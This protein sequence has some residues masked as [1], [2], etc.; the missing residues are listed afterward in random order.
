MKILM[1]A[2]Y[3]ATVY[4][5]PAQVIQQLAQGLGQ[6]G[7]AIDIITTP[8]N[9]QQTLDV[10]LNTWLPA[11]YPAKH[12]AEHPGQHPPQS[13][14]RVQYF[15]C[16]HQNDFILSPALWYWL[17]H[18]VRAYD[19]VHT[20]HRFA[21]LI[22]GAEW[23]CQLRQVPYVATPH[24]MLEP[25]ALAY[26]AWKKRLYYRLFEQP[27][28][29]RARAI[30]SLNATEANHIQALGFPQTIVVPNGIDHQHFA[31]LPDPELFYQQF[32]HTRHKSLILFLG[33]IDR[34]KGLDL[35]APAFA[36]VRDRFPETH[37][38]IAGPDST[39][40][41]PTVQ[42]SLAQ[43]NCLEAVTFTGMLTGRLKHA[44]FAAAQLYVAPSYSEGFS[45]SVLE[46]MGAGLPCIIT[47]GCNFPEASTAKAAWVVEPNAQAI[48]D[49]LIECLTQPQASQQTAE[50]GRQL[51]LQRYTWESITENLLQAYRSLLHTELQEVAFKRVIGNW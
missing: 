17:W 33:R 5:G 12:P 32:P 42:T 2:P 4:G 15:N 9:A 19:L 29:K 40:Y 24:G 11:Q 43:A 21:P 26:K 16:W 48:T 14:Y 23:I 20:H 18:N 30:H 7:V 39:G 47:T 49:A 34:K 3:L 13:T 31:A 1:I 50:R 22:L 44:A 27:A 8:A 45:L 10:P 37:L 41:L 36:A 6:L 25:W 38:V 28:L 51:I 46:G 35:L